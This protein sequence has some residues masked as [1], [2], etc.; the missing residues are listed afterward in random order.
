MEM[1]I[2]THCG[3]KKPISEFRMKTDNRQHKKYVYSQCKECEKITT[4]KYKQKYYEINKEMVKEKS[5]QQRLNNHEEYIEYMKNYYQDNKEEL[6]EKNKEYV[7]KHLEKTKKYQKEY[8]NSHKET[9]KEYDKLYFIDNKEKIIKR[10]YEKYMNDDIYRFKQQIRNTIRSSF[11]RKGYTKRSHTFEIIGIEFDQFKRHLL[12]TYKKTYGVD[13]D[14][15]EKVHIDHIIPLATAKTEEEVIK[16]CHYSNLQL[17]KGE[18][19]LSKGDRID[20]SI[21][22]E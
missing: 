18:D 14:G 16:L 3:I 19:N 8:A 7:K 6:T 11:A 5:R 12:K 1:K 10:M 22:D 2:C 13:W 9:K 17:L 15:V 21:K 4:K 20:W